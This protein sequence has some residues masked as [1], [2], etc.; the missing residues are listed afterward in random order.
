M[1][2]EIPVIG[3]ATYR[4]NDWKRLL[5]ISEDKEV[6]E[7]SWDEWNDNLHR[8]EEE[9]RNKNIKF[10]EVLIDLDELIDFCEDEQININSESRSYF[11]ADKLNNE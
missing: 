4:Y 7:D 10:K 8:Y 5:N 9:L 3:L 1:K 11:V 2:S 6:L